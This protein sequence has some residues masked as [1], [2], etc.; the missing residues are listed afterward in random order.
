MCKVTAKNKWYRD[1]FRDVLTTLGSFSLCGAVGMLAVFV[2]N[3]TRC[4]ISVASDLVG[5]MLAVSQE[6]IEP[7][8]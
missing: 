8:L 7:V 3:C 6:I 4:M 5:S 1:E 2:E